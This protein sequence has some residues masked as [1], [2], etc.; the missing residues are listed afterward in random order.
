MPTIDVRDVKGAVVGQRE[1]PS[2]LFEAPVNV[3]VMHQVVVAGLAAQRA[4]THSTK[5]RGE[6]SGGGKKPWRQKGTGRARH[7]SSRSPI[8]SGGGVAHGPKPRD[9]SVRVNK[10]MR[11]AALRS[12]LSDASRSEK[13]SLLAELAF[14]GPRTKDAIA[15]L[16]TLE[17]RGRIL[18]VIAEPDEALERSFRNLGHVKVGYPGN[19]NTYDLLYADR[20]VFTTGALDALVG[21]LLA[22]RVEEG[23]EEVG[24]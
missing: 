15:L 8:W 13:L 19:L 3:P 17:L 5:T 12:A 1:L 22:D 11:R 2:A 7:G 14:D 4:G 23:P 10:R 21:R 20:V 9:Y 24:A 6:V 16:D 18:F